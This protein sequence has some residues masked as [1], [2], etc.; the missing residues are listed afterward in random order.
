MSSSICANTD[1]SYVCEC[2]K[3]W[4]NRIGLDNVC[5]DFDECETKPCKWKEKCVNS[6]GSFKGVDYFNSFSNISVEKFSNRRFKCDCEDG[7]TKNAND[8]CR[9]INECAK[10][11]CDEKSELCS[12]NDGSYTCFCA[13][14]FRRVGNEC[15]DVN[16]CA[17]FPCRAREVRD[18]LR[19]TSYF[20]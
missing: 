17:G 14:G 6:D 19:F 16:E 8:E 13:S 2:R 15:I 9:D 12:N 7:Y 5:I 18:C 10:N 3:G 20:S 4:Q 11:P 1:G